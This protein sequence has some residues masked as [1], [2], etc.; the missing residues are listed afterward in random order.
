MGNN[1]YGR[2]IIS[3][4]V[5]RKTDYRLPVTQSPSN[6]RERIKA[7]VLLNTIHYSLMTNLSCIL[8]LKIVK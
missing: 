7:G 4:P 1:F 5:T 3:C 6:R 8:Q 2:N